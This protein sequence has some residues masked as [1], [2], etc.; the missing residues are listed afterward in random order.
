MFCAFDDDFSDALPRRPETGAQYRLCGI[1]AGTR[2]ATARGWR[3]VEEI[4]A[5]DLV[6][7]FDNGMQPVQGASHAPAAPPGA[8][9]AMARPVH[10]PADALGNT[11]PMLLLPDQD[12]MV[13]SDLAESIGGD[14]FALIK[15][16]ALVGQCG[17]ERLRGVH[18][19]RSTHL[20]FGSDE[21][22]F[23]DGGALLLAPQDLPGFVPLDMLE[24]LQ[25]PAAYKQYRGAMA[26]AIVADYAAIM[27]ATAT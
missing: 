15:A 1:A 21:L 16:S 13:E 7:T 17:I 25:A 20:H 10:V 2:I 26:Q 3:K 24:A 11:E 19:P 9:P 6:M 23:A 27:A 4:K 18:A 8:L 5:G 12:V 22:V 14:P